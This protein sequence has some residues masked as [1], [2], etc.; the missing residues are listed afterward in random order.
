MV[1]MPVRRP[2]KTQQVLQR[3]AC[4]GAVADTTTLAI[5]LETSPDQINSSL[6]DA[7]SQ[8]LV[9][10]LEG[11][12]LRKNGSRVPVLVGAVRLE[13]DENQGVAFVLD[14]TERRRAE[15]EARESERRY[16]DTDGTGPCKSYRDHG[17]AYCIDCPRGQSADHCDDRQRRS[18]AAMARSQAAGFGGNSSAT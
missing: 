16:R 5:V 13:T 14:L 4:L 10:P 3:F 15:Y 7:L 8:G 12:Y 2:E 18:G 1:G 11:E 9:A 6:W 17:P